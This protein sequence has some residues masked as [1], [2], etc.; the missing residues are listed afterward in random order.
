M[1]NA[2]NSERNYSGYFIIAFFAVFMIDI[3]SR[4]TVVFKYI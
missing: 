4:I 1:F 2:D 3:L